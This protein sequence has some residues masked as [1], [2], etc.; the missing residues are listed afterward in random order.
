MNTLR[1]ICLQGKER[2]LKGKV[3]LKRVDAGLRLKKIKDRRPQKEGLVRS[4]VFH[5]S[6]KEGDMHPSCGGQASLSEI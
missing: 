4:G 3:C 6:E 2:R 5:S 1:I